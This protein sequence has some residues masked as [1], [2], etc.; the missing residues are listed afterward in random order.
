[1]VRENYWLKNLFALTLACFSLS[2]ISNLNSCSIS[3]GKNYFKN[4]KDIYCQVSSKDTSY[5]LPL[6]AEEDTDIIFSNSLKNNFSTCRYYKYRSAILQS[7]KNFTM[8]YNIILIT[9]K[10]HSIRYTIIP[11]P[12]RC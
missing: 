2:I 8:N 11:Y 7:N 4:I 3:L 9:S 1:M 12:L 6:L 10:Y 5:I